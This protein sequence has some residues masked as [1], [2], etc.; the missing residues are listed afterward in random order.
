MPIELLERPPGGPLLL[1]LGE[2]VRAGINPAHYVKNYLC[3]Q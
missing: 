2:P 1:S 3:I